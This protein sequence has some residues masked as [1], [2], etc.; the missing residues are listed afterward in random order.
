MHPRLV[1]DFLFPLHEWIRGRRTLRI[2]ADLCETEAYTADRL[3]ELQWKK[4]RRLL[5]HAFLHNVYYRELF[6]KYSIHPEDIRT[7]SDFAR[8]PL[9]T[10]QIIRQQGESI[11]SQDPESQRSLIRRSTGGSTGEP[12]VF[13]STVRQQAAHN[14]AKFRG[15]SWWGIHLGDR[16]LDMFGHGRTL[17]WKD[18]L[19]DVR[20]SLLNVRVVSAYDLSERAMD[21]T[22]DLLQQWRPH[23][24]YVYPSAFYHF[25]LYLKDKN[26][27]PHGF[28]P[29]IIFSSAETLYDTQ[30][31]LFQEY[32]GARIANEYGAHDGGLIAFECPAGRLHIT[33]EQV[34]VEVL[35]DGPDAN[36]GSLIITDLE[37]Y[38]QPFIRYQIGDYGEM[39]RRECP[40]GRGLAVLEQLLGRS[41]EMLRS[42][43]G[44]PVPGL[45]LTGT[46]REIEGVREFQVVQEE[47]EAIHIRIVATGLF[48]SE[49]LKK[50][51]AE[52][53]RYVGERMKLTFELSNGLERRESGKCSWFISR[54]PSRSVESK[55]T[56]LP[57]GPH[58]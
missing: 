37:N 4:L 1:K 19:L 10:K 6:K 56:V 39:S 33:Q 24:L 28:S 9:L 14:A 47:M 32:Y 44:T 12:L 48:Q 42:A 15:R 23:F 46:F 5:Q 16:E 13:F 31:S 2:L 21:A 43:N 38:G 18:R 41:T 17:A 35:P 45:L 11:V 40:C 57:N 29:K 51:E 58:Q 54:I 7:P 3:H 26:V 53:K 55:G 30:R 50:V 34:Y 20:D 49:S 27:D 8:I 52:L 25:T 22:L 36:R